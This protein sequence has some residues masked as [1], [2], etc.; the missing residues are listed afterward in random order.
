MWFS[1]ETV[2]I[3]AEGLPVGDGAVLILD[4]AGEAGVAELSRSF[5][6]SPAVS[7]RLLPPGWVLNHLRWILLKL[8]ATQ[9]LFPHLR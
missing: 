3:N 2:T 8:A 4:P 5:L 9:R 7:P 1:E 6:S